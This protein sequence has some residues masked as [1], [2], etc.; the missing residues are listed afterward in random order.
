MNTRAVG[1]NIKNC[2]EERGMQQRE[3][4][5]MLG[6]TE[7]T[8]SRWIHGARQ[9]SAFALQRISRIFGATM[10]SM[11]AG[12]TE[13]PKTGGIMIR[14]NNK[15]VIDLDEQSNYMPRIDRHETETVELKDGTTKEKP[16]YGPPIGYYRNLEGALKGIIA[17]EFQSKVM[18]EDITLADALKALETIRANISFNMAQRKLD[19]V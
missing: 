19:E 7:V 6:V 5:D 4:A 15:W 12:T 1:D 2:L 11:M 10:E 17:K 8:I 18:A 3:L 9:P 13:K 16:V 14:V